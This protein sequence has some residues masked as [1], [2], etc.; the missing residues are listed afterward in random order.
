MA[1][2]RLPESWLGR[3]LNIDPA[4]F[5]E[6]R[7]REATKISSHCY[8][9]KEHRPNGLYHTRR[10][11]ITVFRPRA[12]EIPVLRTIVR[13]L[14]GLSEGYCCG[15]NYTEE[16]YIHIC[17]RCG[18]EFYDP[19]ICLACHYHQSDRPLAHYSS[20]RI[21]CETCNEVVKEE[22]EEE[23]VAV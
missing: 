5:K 21:I 10:T 7:E 1:S 17:S 6:S 12:D 3:I 15:P 19:K 18:E 4:K 23:E 16:I 8:D 22:K 20:R 13:F 14:F 2:L 11:R 9:G